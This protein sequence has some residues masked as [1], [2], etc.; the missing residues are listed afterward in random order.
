[1]LYVVCLMTNPPL[2]KAQLSQAGRGEGIR[3][4]RIMQSDACPMSCKNETPC[5]ERVI[6]LSLAMQRTE[7]EHCLG[8]AYREREREKKRERER[9]IYIHIDS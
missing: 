1:M 9:D 3:H 4:G 7:G 6:L 8:E 5:N 2:P